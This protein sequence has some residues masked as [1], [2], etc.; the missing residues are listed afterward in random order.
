[1]KTKT[2][3]ILSIVGVYFLFT[4]LLFG[5]SMRMEKLESVEDTLYRNQGVALKIQ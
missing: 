5:V 3:K 1:M 4:L 2:K